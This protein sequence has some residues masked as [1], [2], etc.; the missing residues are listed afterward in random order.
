[1]MQMVKR[2]YITLL[3]LIS[4]LMIPVSSMYAQSISKY[5]GEFLST[6][7]GARALGV[8]SAFVGVANDVT[9]GY[10]NAAGLA[11][12]KNKQA[13]AMHSERFAGI[14]TYDYAA[15]G[16]PYKADRAI[17]FSVIRLGVDGI[18]N[19]TDALLDYGSDGIPGTN[20]PDGSEGNG[21]LDDGERLDENKITRFGD[22][23]WAMFLSYGRQYT[24]KL[25]YGGSVKF[26][27]K[28][29]ADHSAHGLGFDVGVR[30]KLRENMFFGAN[31]QD[32]TTTLLAWDTGTKELIAP[33]F[34][35][36][37]SAAFDLPF[38]EASL[39]PTAELVTRTEGTLPF[40]NGTKL[41]PLYAA[42]TY[43][44]ELQVNEKLTLRVGKGEI[45]PFSAGIG[46]LVRGAMIDYSFGALDS[47]GEL[48]DT[49]R[50]S[51]MINFDKSL[52][53]K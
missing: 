17:A 29:F 38:T 10:W 50:V 30:Y 7:V 12:L 31:V 25:A 6:G 47:G 45:E 36:G 52:W 35:T 39:L 22:S 24:D 51:V 20:D 16:Q 27:R 13:I 34:R 44:A 4:V 41:G 40:G 49:H 3:I 26:L 33:T 14:V 28:A 5:A 11:E 53:S 42:F 15:Y 19:T 46:V 23:E 9:A 32:V 21:Q 8:G 43:G 2:F 1:M 48:G 18:P 37:L